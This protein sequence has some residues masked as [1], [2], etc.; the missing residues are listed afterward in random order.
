MDP[1]EEAR[2]SLES[3]LFRHV[4]LP[5]VVRLVERE[6]ATVGERDAIA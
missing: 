3:L 4:T 5:E 1:A 2:S 6:R